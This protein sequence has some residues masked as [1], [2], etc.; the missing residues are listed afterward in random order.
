MNQT[1]HFKKHGILWQC[2]SDKKPG[3]ANSTYSELNRNNFD[4]FCTK[5]LTMAQLGG[6]C[7]VASVLSRAFCKVAWGS[8][9]QCYIGSNLYSSLQKNWPRECDIDSGNKMFTHFTRSW[10]QKRSDFCVQTQDAPK[11][12]F[13]CNT[14]VDNDHQRLNF[15]A[16][17]QVILS[18]SLVYSFCM[19][20]FSRDTCCL[21]KGLMHSMSN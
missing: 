1:N 5:I 14:Q 15:D 6:D 2:D 3:G 7:E 13:G 18:Y 4:Y 17:Y 8:L 20:M 9:L 19:F 10:I 21:T 11:R 16:K 12:N